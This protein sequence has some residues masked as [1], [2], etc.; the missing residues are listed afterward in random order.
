MRFAHQI[1]ITSKTAAGKTS[2]VRELRKL[3]PGD[4]YRWVSGG[5]I[6]RERAAQFGMSIEEFAAHNRLHPEEGHDKWLD[7]HIATLAEE[8]GMV[9]DGRLVHFFMPGAFKV[10]IECDLATRAGRRHKDESH[11]EYWRV[12]REIEKRDQDDEERYTKLYPGCIWQPQQ[13]D[14]VLDSRSC[15]PDMLA[16]R[17]VREHADWLKC[18]VYEIQPATR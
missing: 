6:M 8:D 2:L 14:L 3:L 4:S 15:F 13:F 5:S 9:C 7:G 16:R 17:L 1:S 12:E 11:K 18:N 10:W